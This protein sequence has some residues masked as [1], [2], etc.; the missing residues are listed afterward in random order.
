[1]ATFKKVLLFLEVLEVPWIYIFMSTS[2]FLLLKFKFWSHYSRK[3]QSRCTKNMPF[4]I[5]GRF[6]TVTLMLSFFGPV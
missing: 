2:I 6:V 3:G 1:M 4:G 5:N